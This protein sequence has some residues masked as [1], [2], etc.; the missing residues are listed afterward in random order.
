MEQ[1]WKHGHHTLKRIQCNSENSK[2]V[3]CLQYDDHKIVSG[4][5]D[6]T[7]KVRDLVGCRKAPI[8]KGGRCWI[9]SVPN[10]YSQQY[11][12]IT[13]YWLIRLMSRLN[14]YL[15]QIKLIKCTNDCQQ[16]ILDTEQQQ[17]FFE[18]MSVWGCFCWRH[19]YK[20]HLRKAWIVA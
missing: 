19:V 17:Q 7:I 6:N 9:D 15:G 8:R 16:R 13:K 10:N 1:N 5:R 2:G 11:L 20:I 12:G 4:L 18:I 3:Y 14:L